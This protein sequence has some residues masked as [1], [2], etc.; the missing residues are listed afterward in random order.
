MTM[1]EQE[2]KALT[3]WFMYTDPW[4]SDLKREHD[5]IRDLLIRASK[6]HGFDSWEAAFHGLHWN[7]TEEV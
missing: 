5:V 2:L 6:E 1:T 7:E 4:P 3:G